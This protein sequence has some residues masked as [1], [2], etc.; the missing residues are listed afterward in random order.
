[1]IGFWERAA[2][3]LLFLLEPSRETPEIRKFRET[4]VGNSG[5]HFGPILPASRIRPFERTFREVSSFRVLGGAK[6]RLPNSQDRE[7]KR[8]EIDPGTSVHD[9]SKGNSR[10]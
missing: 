3:A 7:R 4:L 5:K 8:A 1:M 2:G 6:W 9:Q 10:E